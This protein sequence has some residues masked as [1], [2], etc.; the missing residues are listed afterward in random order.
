MHCKYKLFKKHPPLS[1]SK[2]FRVTRHA[3]SYQLK[4][5]GVGLIEALIAV[6]VMTIGLLGMS[7]MML[8]AQKSKQNFEQST[9]A[10]QVL[11]IAS[12]TMRTLSFTQNSNG[13]EGFLDTPLCNN[14]NALCNSAITQRQAL[15]TQL[16]SLLPGATLNIRHASNAANA[17]N[18]SFNNNCDAPIFMRLVTKNRLNS[19]Q[20]TTVV[21]Q[22]TSYAIT[23]QQKAQWGLSCN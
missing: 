14:S 10:I 5:Q 15:N 13:L 23:P 6:L 4:H 12:E 22:I 8:T 2:Y 17:K 3:Q 16:N 1:V 21:Q 19:N 11:E 20:S 18:G 9:E 7:R